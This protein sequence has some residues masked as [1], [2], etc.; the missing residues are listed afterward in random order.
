M[1]LKINTSKCH[2]LNG[3]KREQ[4]IGEKTSREQTMDLTSSRRGFGMIVLIHL[5]YHREEVFLKAHT[6]RFKKTGLLAYSNNRHACNSS[7]DVNRAVPVKDDSI[8]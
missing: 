3:I 4:T 5:D 2:S 7:S 8:G 6:T 1:D